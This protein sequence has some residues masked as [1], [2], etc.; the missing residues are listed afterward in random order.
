MLQ[1]N[2]M[3]LPDLIMRFFSTFSKICLKYMLCYLAVLVHVCSAHF[4]A[5]DTPYLVTSL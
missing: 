2:N 1:P 4:K 3:F 5:L